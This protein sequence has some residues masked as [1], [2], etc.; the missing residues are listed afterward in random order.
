VPASRTLEE[1]EGMALANHPA[2]ARAAAR[3]RAAQGNAWQ[4]GRPPNPRIGY[5]GEEIGDDGTAGMQG[6]FVSQEFI[7]GGKLGLNRA[8][9]LQRVAVAEAEFE[10]ERLRV[11]AD[12]R[13]EFYR[14]LSAQREVELS[15]ELSGVGEKA[16]ETVN[17]L[18]RAGTAS[19]VEL[20]QA[21]VEAEQ[22]RLA[23]EQARQRHRATWRRLASA[24]A[25]PDLPLEPLAGDLAKDLPTFEYD[26]VLAELMAESP[27][28]AAARAEAARAR[29]MVERERREPIPNL[30]VT[31]G[32]AKHFVSGDTMAN[33][34]M[35][36]PIPLW[37][38]NEGGITRAMG[39]QMAAEAEISRVELALRRR[40]ADAFERYENAR[41]EAD[42]YAKQILP[43]ARDSLELVNVAYRQGELSFLTALTSQRTY[44]RANLAYLAALRE[45][46]A[47]AVTLETLLLGGEAGSG[48]GI[49]SIMAE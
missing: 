19:R 4:V 18:L 42:R 7:R 35:E 13:V 38:R 6:G 41:I 45:L 22:A 40:L 15:R 25:A 43:A 32:V 33:V 12:V 30:T 16:V 23:F 24:L 10:A 14:V 1:L 21:Q 2:L 26:A 28:L 3:M 47:T 27:E 34:M 17:A 11:V 29:F 20:L 49:S 31:A 39:E 9:A 36:L 37:D 8:A 48:R 46:R 44:F 5:S